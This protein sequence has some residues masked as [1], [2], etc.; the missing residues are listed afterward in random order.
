MLYPRHP[1]LQLGPK[2][3]LLSKGAPHSLGTFILSLTFHFRARTSSKSQEQTVG[4]GVGFAQGPLECQCCDP[5]VL[6]RGRLFQ[7]SW[8]QEPLGS[9]I[10]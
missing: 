5:S 6:K 10:I 4:W 8:L 9:K 2:A 3:R 7:N 1:L